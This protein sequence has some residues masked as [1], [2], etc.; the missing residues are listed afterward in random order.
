VRIPSINLRVL[1]N[2]AALAA[3]YQL[4]TRIVA[5]QT[6]AGCTTNPEKF[7]FAAPSTD[8]SGWMLQPALP[9]GQYSVCVQ[10]LVP[11]SGT[12]TKKKSVTVNNYFHRGIKPSADPS[13]PLS[14]VVDLNS[15][16]VNGTC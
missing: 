13:A 2:G 8:V 3:T 7:T 12:T 6:S 15:G 10:S 1:Y 5:T 14:P 9:F 11:G 4:T 16:T